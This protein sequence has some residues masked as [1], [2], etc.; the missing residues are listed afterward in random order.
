M[1][2]RMAAAALALLGVLL[3]TYLVL[4][5]YGVTGPLVCGGTE[6]CEQVQA[7]RYAVVFGI[8][9]AVVG[10]G[11]YL[12]LLVVALAG[13]QGRLASRPGPTRL[14]LLLSGLGV[15]FTIYLTYLELVRIHAVCRWCVGSA[16]II[17]AIFAASIA[18][19]RQGSEGR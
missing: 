15:A 3:A 2:H 5:H 8:P 4:Y 12:V 10:L 7:S 6:S 19:V 14:L 13:L 1:R 18:G 17:T 11:G 16:V 9:V